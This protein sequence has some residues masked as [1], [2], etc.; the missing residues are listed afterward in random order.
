MMG[1]ADAAV[2]L[3]QELVALDTVN[4]A[5]VSGAAGERPAV[6]LLAA[7]LDRRGFEIEIVG[8]FERPSLLATHRGRA[9]GSS[10]ALNG[11]LDTVGVDGMHDPFSAR[12]EG[13]RMYGRGT[14][15]MKAGVA[16]M[17]VAGEHAADA[18]HDG[19]V[20]LAL[21]ADEEHASLGT[22]AV[23]D[24]LAGRLPDACVVGEPTWLD[25]IIAHRGFAAIEVEI[26]GRAAHSSR[27]QDGVNAV[28]LL[29]RLLGAVEERDHQLAARDPHPY[30]G[31]GSM[32]ATVVK[33]GSAPFILAATAS[34]IVERRTV[35]GEPLDSGLR[36][37]ESIIQRLGLDA[38]CREL[39]A[40][41]PWELSD[42]AAAQRLVE[43]LPFAGRAGHSAWMESAMWE[44][45]G[46]PAV[47][48]GPAGGGLHTT[49]EWVELPQ[50]RAY[51]EALAALTIEFGR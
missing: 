38:E 30:A 36:E 14:C 20:V 23:L 8:P 7:R 11:H 29:G 45:A 18:G 25:V 46:V 32:M 22:A 12:I 41:D 51:A 1:V 26:C 5:L 42:A 43:L 40:R 3:T 10:L 34:A 39:V 9:G 48:C 33:G 37:V 35:P 28:T 4:P 27:P 6:E 15:D 19:D 47:V 17:V 21:V 16:A 31:Q 50:L 2:E 49:V 13:D 24:H 44:T